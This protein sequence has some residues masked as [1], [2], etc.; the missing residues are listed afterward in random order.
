MLHIMQLLL[1]Y[2]GNS[3][4]VDIRRI[5]L[6]TASNGFTSGWDMLAGFVFGIEL[7]RKKYMASNFEYEQG[8]VC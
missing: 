6:E 8:C 1:K 3:G 4:T 7:F 2:Y 5:L